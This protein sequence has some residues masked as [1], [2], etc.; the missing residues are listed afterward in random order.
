MVVRC[1]IFLILCSQLCGKDKISTYWEEGGIIAVDLEVFEAKKPWKR[2]TDLKGFTGNSYWTWRG[3]NSFGRAGGGTIEFNIIISRPGEYFLNIYNRHDFHD[4][5]EENDCFTQMDDGKWVKTFSSKKGEW[6]W[7]STHEWSGSKKIPAA[8]TLSAGLHTFRI[9]GRSKNFSIDRVHLWH[10]SLNKKKTLSTDVKLTDSD[11]PAK[12]SSLQNKRLTSYWNSGKFGMVVRESNALLQK[13]ENQEASEAIEAVAAFAEK[14]KE[15]IDKL[16]EF[17]PSLAFQSLRNLATS[18]S[19][20]AHEKE[21][22]EEI[23]TLSRDKNF[24]MSLQSEKIYLK[25]LE[26]IQKNNS[27]LVKGKPKPLSK[28]TAESLIKAAKD[29]KRYC[30]D[31]PLYDDLAIKLE[32][33]NITLE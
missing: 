21:I 6:I 24:Q 27:K 31:S 19:Y 16:K 17:A 22:K 18:L 11:I 12:P 1:V 2:E 30:P 9:S 23:M 3:G 5:T 8:Y 14:R 4:S 32:K 28:R 26:T 33:M 15:Q 25:A 13:G 20:T 29:I 10:S 7:Q